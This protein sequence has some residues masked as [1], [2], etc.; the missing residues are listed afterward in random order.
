MTT[1]KYV[2]LWLWL[3]GFAPILRELSDCILRTAE[4]YVRASRLRTQ[5]RNPQNRLTCSWTQV[6]FVFLRPI[7]A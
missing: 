6:M 7:L 5:S 4:K 3:E 2:I 1:A